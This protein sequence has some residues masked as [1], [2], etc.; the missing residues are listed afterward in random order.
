MKKCPKCGN[1]DID[2]GSLNVQDG[3]FEIGYRSKRKKILRAHSRIIP[4]VCLKCGYT[5]LYTVVKHLKK[6]IKDE[7]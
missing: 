4:F 1:L 7:S 6:R 5:E 3:L 2:D